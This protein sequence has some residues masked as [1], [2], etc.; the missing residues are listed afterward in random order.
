MFVFPRTMP[1]SPI[2]KN[3]TMT[4][5]TAITAAATTTTKKS[6]VF[7][8]I[9]NNNVWFSLRPY[10][11]RASERRVGLECKEDL[12]TKQKIDRIVHCGRRKKKHSRLMMDTTKKKI[13]INLPTQDKTKKFTNSMH[14][15]R[16]P[17]AQY[18]N[19]NPVNIMHLKLVP[20]QEMAYF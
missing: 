2:I 13:P 8:S 6:H 16:I 14:A 18:Y 5:S 4:I 7:S 10:A 9:T 15:E 3:P 12:T 1:I 17:S 11:V 19:R 20:K